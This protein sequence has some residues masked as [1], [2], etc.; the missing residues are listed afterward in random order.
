M[1]LTSCQIT[2][3]NY[4]ESCIKLSDDEDKQT[5]NEDDIGNCLYELNLT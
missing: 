3:N 2:P 4:W 1:K 5:G